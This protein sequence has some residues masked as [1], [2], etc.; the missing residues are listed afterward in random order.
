[1]GKKR[2]VGEIYKMFP[3]DKYFQYPAITTSLKGK[4]GT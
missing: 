3:S 2:K 1:M 4:V